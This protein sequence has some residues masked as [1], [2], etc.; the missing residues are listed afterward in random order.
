[1]RTNP[2]EDRFKDLLMLMGN[3]QMEGY[4]GLPEDSIKLPAECVIRGRDENNNEVFGDIDDLISHTFGET[5]DHNDHSNRAILTPLNVD[6]LEIN[7][8]V[9]NRLTGDHF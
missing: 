5:L 8:K 3:G 7:E 9:L 6:S 1:M 2:D 4:E